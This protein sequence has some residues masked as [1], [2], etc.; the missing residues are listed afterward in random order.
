[1]QEDDLA[2]SA[3]FDGMNRLSST[4]AGGLV[5]VA[6]TLSEPGT[7]TVQGQPGEVLSDN[8]FKGSTTIGSGNTNVVVQATDPSGN[9]R[10]NTY[11]LSASG[12]ATSYS[13]DANGNLTSDGTKTFEWD[14]LDRLVAVKQGAATLASFTYD[15]LGRRAQKLAGGL[16]R[17]YLHE[18]M[19]ILEERLSTGATT[20]FFHGPGVDQLFARQSGATATYYLTDHLGSIAQETNSSA[21]V[22]LSRKYDP[23]GNITAGA[24]TGG[25]AFTGNVPTSVEF[26]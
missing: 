18:G 26:G 2:Q 11:Q 23:W 3:S 21:A 14:A 12:G 13:Y 10:T 25:Y 15:G 19:D 5:H 17:T 20:R 24:F 4:Q 1:L 7:V 8:R 6:G 22:T 16:T 9:V